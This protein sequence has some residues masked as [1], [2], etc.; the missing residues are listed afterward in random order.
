MHVFADALV[1]EYEKLSTDEYLNTPAKRRL[2]ATDKRYRSVMGTGN[3]RELLVLQ[4]IEWF[5]DQKQRHHDQVRIINA[6]LASSARHIHGDDYYDNFEDICRRYNMDKLSAIC[7]VLA[8]R[9]W[10]KTQMTSI[11]KASMFMHVPE[12]TGII[13]SNSL[14]PAQEMMSKI[15][16]L[17]ALIP[18]FKERFIVKTEN[19]T[20]LEVLDSNKLIRKLRC[21]PLNENISFACAIFRSPIIQTKVGRYAYD[22]NIGTIYCILLW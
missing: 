1:R 10:G 8:P 14:R 11:V 2:Y 16:E 4:Q 9:R 22:K 7:V 17:K 19:R 15:Y 3:E 5:L 12:Y 20:E 13:F 6:Q 18:D 21:V